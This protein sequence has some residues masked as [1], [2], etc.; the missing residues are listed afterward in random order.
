LSSSDGLII[1]FI[2]ITGATAVVTLENTK[3]IEE[4]DENDDDYFQIYNKE[5]EIEVL[6]D[7]KEKANI[8]YT[9]TVHLTSRLTLTSI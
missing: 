2:T 7:P 3:I 8:R 4:N 1:T 9:K 5:Y 6:I